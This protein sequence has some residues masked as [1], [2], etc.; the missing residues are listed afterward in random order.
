MVTPLRIAFVE[1]PE[2]L[3]TGDAQW[4]EM[5]NSVIAARP[6]IL[7]TNELPFGPW[8]ADG[9]TFSEDEARFSLCAH[10]KGLE[11]LIDLALPAVIS[12]RPVWN[13]QVLPCPRFWG[14]RSEYLYAR[15]RC[16]T[17]ARGPTESNRFPWL[18]YLGRQGQK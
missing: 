18:S 11:G 4:G 6:D 15:K 13:V 14:L 2:G 12:S 3:S 8:L 5:R 17:N 7:L 10:E 9:A 16:S 1:W